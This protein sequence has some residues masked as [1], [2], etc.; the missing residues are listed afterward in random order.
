MFNLNRMNTRLILINDIEKFCID[1]I[2][3]YNSSNT[4]NKADYFDLLSRIDHLKVED[5]DNV[6]KQSYFLDYINQ[7]ENKVRRFAIEDALEGKDISVGL[8]LYLS[9]YMIGLG[10]WLK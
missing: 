6:E 7:A 9:N 4:I 10:N 3:E 8:Y 2:T 5:F 1:S